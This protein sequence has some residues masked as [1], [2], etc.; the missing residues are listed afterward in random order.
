MFGA[1]AAFGIPALSFIIAFNVAF[2][3]NMFAL[4]CAFNLIEAGLDER[5]DERKT[6][7]VWSNVEHNVRLFFFAVPRES[8]PLT[9]SAAQEQSSRT[10]NSPR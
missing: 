10:L 9:N 7:R 8:T 6:A 3:G 4:F 1:F 2:W 5:L